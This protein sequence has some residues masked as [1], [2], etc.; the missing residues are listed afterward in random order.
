[1]EDDASAAGVKPLE[2]NINEHTQM[3]GWGEALESY[4]FYENLHPL[5]LGRC[6]RK[7]IDDVFSED[8]F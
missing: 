8:L 1:M 3:E 7:A 2:G 6:L 5:E 4:T